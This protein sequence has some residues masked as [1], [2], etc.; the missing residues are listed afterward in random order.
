MKYVTNCGGIVIFVTIFPSRKWRLTHQNII[1]TTLKQ[2]EILCDVSLP[3]LI[4][5]KDIIS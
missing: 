2:A 3:T 5:T 4:K 1:E